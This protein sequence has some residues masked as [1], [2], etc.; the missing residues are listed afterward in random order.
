ME[1]IGGRH[2]QSSSE[3]GRR[4]TRALWLAG[5]LCDHGYAYKEVEVTDDEEEL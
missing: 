1:W 4:K 3:I 5:G 2:I